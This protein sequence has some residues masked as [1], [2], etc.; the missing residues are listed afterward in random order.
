[1]LTNDTHSAENDLVGLGAERNVG[2]DGVVRLVRVGEERYLLS[3][4]D[5]VVEVDTRNTRGDE[6]RRLYTLV[7]VYGRAPDLARL[8]FDRLSALDRFSVGVEEASGKVVRNLQL[9]R[10]AVEDDLRVGGQTL[11]AGE[12]LQRDGV[13]HDLHHLRKLSAHGGEFVI[14]YAGSAERHRRLGNVVDFGIYLLKCSCCHIARLFTLFG[15]ILFDLPLVVVE[16]LAL[17]LRVVHLAE[18]VDEA[19]E[20]LRARL[21]IGEVE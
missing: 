1:M 17:P 6:L 12:Y 16:L 15:N 10:L 2:H 7:R 3:G 18:E 20:E 11:R 14:A 9:R 21:E 8:A 4:H 5:G 13:A 19:L